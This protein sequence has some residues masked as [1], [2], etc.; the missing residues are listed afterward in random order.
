M[1]A[2][3]TGVSAVWHQLSPETNSRAPATASVR[4]QNLAA[5]SVRLYNRSNA[6]R[7]SAALCELSGLNQF[8]SHGFCDSMSPI[9]CSKRFADISDHHFDLR[10]T[11]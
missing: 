4:D 2:Q 9:F 5:E 10:F 7:T 8:L 6:Q 3:I 11:Y 1:Q